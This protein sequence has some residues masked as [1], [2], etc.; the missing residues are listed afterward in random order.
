MRRRLLWAG[1]V[2]AGLLCAVAV[3]LLSPRSRPLAPDGM[4]AVVAPA[5][6]DAAGRHRPPTTNYTD[7]PGW[8]TAGP[9]MVAALQTLRRRM[10]ASG[11]HT[12]PALPCMQRPGK[13]E[14][15][16]FAR[17]PPP[18]LLKQLFNGTV[19][20]SDE[21]LR[22]AR[23][24]WPLC[25]VGN[26]ARA[27]D[28]VPD[29]ALW[30][31]RVAHAVPALVPHDGPATVR[32]S[33]AVDAIV[34]AVP[35]AVVVGKSG[36]V[37]SAAAVFLHSHRAPNDQTW[38]PSVGRAVI[39]PRETGTVINLLA[40]WGETT[41]HFVM[42]VVPR[43]TLVAPL[44]R[45]SP[46]VKVLAF[47]ENK[48]LLRW[49]FPGLS[50]DRFVWAR[51]E[52]LI[53]ADV[54]VT[55]VFTNAFGWS[56]WAGLPTWPHGMVAISKYLRDALQAT[57]PIPE[58]AIATGSRDDNR[59]ATN[60]NSTVLYVSRAPHRVRAVC[61]EEALLRAVAAALKPQ[62]RL[63][64][65]QDP[66]RPV[67]QALNAAVLMGPHG[68][69][70][71]NLVFMAAGSH[72]VEFIPLDRGIARPC[73]VALAAAS[74]VT[75]HHVEPTSGFDFDA[76]QCMHIDARRVVRALVAAGV[77]TGHG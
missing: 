68:G 10:P 43:L 1:A 35:H 40:L 59:T 52:D 19:D 24:S 44:V 56:S 5:Q 64:V 7:A 25:F 62:F 6:T 36:V 67:R 30:R 23:R 11:L 8:A 69:A 54:V 74:G 53:P 37:V 9:D 47:L 3:R 58:L 55:P 33:G 48:K 61:Q 4:I 21:P 63:V 76:R 34:M 60:A 38:V 13:A 12:A 41:P 46:D 77:A 31:R 71:S 15:L 16:Q 22:F 75:Y 70:F 2:A 17:A 51:A 18:A 39:R 42:D 66:R 72:A 57:P 29:L 45:A 49:V 26:L 20:A 65:V 73:H 27:A 14:V 28:T 50:D 32:I